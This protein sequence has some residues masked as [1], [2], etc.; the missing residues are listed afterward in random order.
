MSENLIFKIRMA[1]YFRKLLLILKQF[2]F[3]IVK[4]IFILYDHML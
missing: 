4:L 3:L 2:I 1:I